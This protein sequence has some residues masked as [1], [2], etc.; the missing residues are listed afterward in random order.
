MSFQ[1][2][3]KYGNVA[4]YVKIE[5]KINH[6]NLKKINIFDGNNDGR[7]FILHKKF[8]NDILFLFNN[9]FIFNEL[10]KNLSMIL[11]LCRKF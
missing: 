1:E 2:K 4:K 7:M 3:Q 6:D 9:N 11:F 5:E 8:N 10:A